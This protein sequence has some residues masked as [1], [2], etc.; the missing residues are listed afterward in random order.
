MAKNPK[1]QPQKRKP[2]A[3]AKAKPNY[4][5]QKA[6]IWL[7][8]LAP[9]LGLSGVVLV[10]SYG[11]LPDTETLA[12]PKT[13]LATQ[14]FSADGKL[15]GRYYS[16][17]RSDIRFNELPAN[18][19]NA[20]IST[21]DARFYS[22]SG[23]D[24]IGLARAIAYM[25]ARGGG[26]TLTQQLAKQLFTEQYDRTSW[27]ERALL[28][29][30]KEWISAA[31][32]ER[33]Y[34]K[35]E[36]V[37]LYLNRYD[38]L[39]QAVGIKSAANIYFDKEVTELAVH[40]SAMLVGMLKNSSLFNPLRREELVQKRRNVVFGQLARYGEISVAA[41]DSLAELPLGLRRISGK[42]SAAN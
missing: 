38:F 16:E 22:H 2:K 10:A 31:R 5:R 34:T 27:L 35:E 19:V 29:K 25:G 18:L 12:N 33:H 7:L 4:A 11:D 42:T 30:P 1:P 36:I 6:W 28:Q 15:I 41:K 21:E 9:M 32:L 37:A 8:G 40:E 26:S 14:V 17:N 13:E 39:N 24:F 23:I 20:L 3:K